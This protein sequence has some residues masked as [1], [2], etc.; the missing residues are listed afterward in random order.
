MQQIGDT[1]VQALTDIHDALDAGQRKTVADFI[2][3]HHHHH[4]G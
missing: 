3:A 1:V 2:V 4:G